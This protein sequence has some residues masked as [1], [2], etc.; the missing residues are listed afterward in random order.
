MSIAIEL[1]CCNLTAMK[2]RNSSSIIIIEITT[3]L[4][5]L[6]WIYTGLSKLIGHHAFLLQLQQQPF[7]QRFGPVISVLIPGIELSAVGLLIFKVTRLIGLW[8]SVVL[9]AVFTVYIALILLHVFKSIPCSCG[10][11]LQQMG[12]KT[13]LYF[14]IFYLLVSLTGLFHH[15]GK[16]AAVTS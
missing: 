1:H 3:S 5:I 15:T 8:L 12:W 2:I 9:M 16:E 11:V 13:H 7:D 10:G 14:N 4:L 6:L